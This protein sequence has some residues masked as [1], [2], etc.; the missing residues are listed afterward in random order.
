MDNKRLNSREEFFNICKILTDEGIDISKLPLRVSKQKGVRVSTTIADINL[1]NIDIQEIIEKYNLDPNYPLGN[2]IKNMRSYIKEFSQN[3]SQDELQLAE[4]LGISKKENE[5]ATPPLV[6]GGKISQFHI[7]FLNGIL[8]KIL[9][10]KINNTE[11]FKLLQQACIDSNETVLSDLGS[12]RSCIEIM[13]KDR[14]EDLKKYN[15]TSSQN[16]GKRNYK[17]KFDSVSEDTMYYEKEEVVRQKIINDYLPQILNGSISINRALEELNIGRKL[18]ND[19]IVQYYQ[20]INDPEGL[21]EYEQR[22]SINGGR[23]E[24]NLKNAKIK[25]EEVLNYNIST[26]KEF[27]FLPHEEQV[28]QLIMK[29]QQEQLKVEAS[30]TNKTKTALTSEE[31]IKKRI[32]ST[33]DYFRGKNPKDS[34]QIYF[35]DQDIMMMCYR[36]PTL[37]HYDPESLDKKIDVFISNEDIGQKDAYGMMKTFPAILGYSPERTKKQLELL[38]KENIVSKM[39]PNP[40]IAMLS[41]PLMYALIEFTKEQRHTSDLTQFKPSTIFMSNSTLE[42]LYGLSHNDIKAK[43][44]YP[45]KNLDEETITEISPDEIGKATYRSRDKSNEANKILKEALLSQE[46]VNP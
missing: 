34:S 1:P 42:K 2:K 11:A 15:E 33:L 44:P 5:T 31:F 40:R 13:L 46:R 28:K 19:T 35:S 9:T 38:G 23:T 10:G 22:K 32:A 16:L 3:F 20:S 6:K 26:I 7:D 29:I 37:I 17:R 36:Y 12:I 21:K 8:D 4:S 45:D 43:Y 41:V 18:F 25:R 14:P 24:E 39:V 30:K 27:S